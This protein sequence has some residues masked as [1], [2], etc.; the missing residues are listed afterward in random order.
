MVRNVHVRVI[1][2]ELAVNGSGVGE[3]RELGS[4]GL[5]LAGV[6]VEGGVR[7]LHEPVSDRELLVGEVTGLPDSETGWVAV[8][9]VVRLGNVAHVV[10]LLARIVLVNV[11]GLAIDGTLEVVTTILNSPEPVVVLVH[12]YLVERQNSHIVIVE[13]N[14]DLVTLTVAGVPAPGNVVVSAAWYFAQV[15]DLDNGTRRLGVRST[16]V[17]VGV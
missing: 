17:D 1:G 4:N 16:R 14:T 13:C 3:E 8:P 15:K 10:D 2:I 12:I 9:V 11:L 5:L 7:C 6:V